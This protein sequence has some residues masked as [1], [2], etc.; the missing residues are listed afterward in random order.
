MSWQRRFCIFF[1]F[2]I[3]A[4]FQ[5]CGGFFLKVLMLLF[6][7]NCDFCTSWGWRP[8]AMETIPS[9]QVN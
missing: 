8:I 4:R 2:L 6:F 3:N 1:L 7:L 9:A 5:G